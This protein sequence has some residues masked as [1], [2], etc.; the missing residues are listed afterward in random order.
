MCPAIIHYR[1]LFALFMHS[2]QSLDYT[3]PIVVNANTKRAYVD[4]MERGIKTDDA[5]C[6]WSRVYPHIGGD[7]IDKKERM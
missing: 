6:A 1:R 5:L 4:A 2:N 3:G 7:R